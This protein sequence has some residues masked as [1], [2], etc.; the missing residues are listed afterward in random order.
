MLTTSR[1]FTANVNGEM[2]DLPA[3]PV[4]LAVGVLHRKDYSSFIADSTIILNPATDT[5]DLGTACTTELSGNLTTKEAY[6]EV[7]I[8]VLKDMPFAHSLNVD[9]GTR[10]SKFNLAGNTT[11]SKLAVEWRPIEDLL[12]RGTVSE[13]FRAPNISELFAGAQSDAPTAQDPCTG[14]VRVSSRVSA[15]AVRRPVRPT[16]RP[17]VV[18][19]RSPT[20]RSTRSLR[21][22]WL[23]ASRSGRKAARAS[24]SAW[25]MIRAGSKACRSVPT[26][27][28]S[29]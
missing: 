2:F 20:P 16:F 29:T 21:V 28:A 15:L 5:C 14:Y 4:S 13:V 8:P 1:E 25:S 12:M 26:T 22:P 9:I 23:Q 27:T 18:L 11:N 6:A 19:L 24:T 7:F 3:G 10:Y 17:T